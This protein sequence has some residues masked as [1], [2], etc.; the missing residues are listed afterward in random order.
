MARTRPPKE[1][2]LPAAAPLASGTEA[3]VVALLEPPVVAVSLAEDSLAEDPLVEALPV[4]AG[5]VALPPPGAVTMGVTMETP[6]TMGVAVAEATGVETS[7]V[8][9]VDGETTE[10]RGTAEE[11]T[12]VATEVA[13]GAWI[14][15]S[16]IW[17]MGWTL[18]WGTAA[19]AP[20]RRARE[21]AEKRILIKYG[22]GW[23][24]LEMLVE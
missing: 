3:V 16:E 17:E 10:G 12:E 13:G 18:Y 23:L 4:A 2:M 21:A 20:A 11:A 22:V 9:E 15:P 14:W 1:T 24:V 8:A 7:A 6:G 19:T 5:T